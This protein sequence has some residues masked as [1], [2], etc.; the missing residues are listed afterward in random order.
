MP[1]YYQVRILKK[2]GLSDREI[3]NINF[4][5]FYD[6]ENLA[7]AL[8]HYNAMYWVREIINGRSGKYFDF[9]KEKDMLIKA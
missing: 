4:D 2:D 3:A 6:A 8:S 5:H 1:D 7:R 9:D